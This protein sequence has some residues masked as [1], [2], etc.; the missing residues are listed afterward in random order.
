MIGLNIIMGIA[1]A[2]LL[3]G[4]LGEKEKEKQQNITIAFVGVLALII[5][6]NT[7]M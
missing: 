3:I 2:V 6:A 1:A 7:I 4:V 5:T